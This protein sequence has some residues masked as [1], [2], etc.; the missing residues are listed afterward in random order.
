VAYAIVGWGLGH[1]KNKFTLNQ[2]PLS[3]ATFFD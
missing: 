2:R 3:L 1:V